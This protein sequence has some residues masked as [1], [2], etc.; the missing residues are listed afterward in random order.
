MNRFLLIGLLFL[1]FTVQAELSES[2]RKAI[3]HDLKIA[4]HR[5][6]IEAEQRY[7]IDATHVPNK[8]IKSYDWHL[9]AIN[10]NKEEDRLI[11]KYEEK[12]R[13][14]YSL[15]VADIEKISDEGL[16]NQWFF[17]EQ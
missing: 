13:K 4:N 10:H 11:E 6:S 12:V 16:G 9:A 14:K 17:D 5:A 3:Y 8:Q 15:S 2:Q 7:P 1:S